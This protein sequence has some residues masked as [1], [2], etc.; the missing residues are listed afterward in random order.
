MLAGIGFLTVVT[1]VITSTF[2]ESAKRHLQGTE[3]DALSAKL[4]R[5][6]ER[7][8]VIEASLKD[9]GGHG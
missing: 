7:L 4:D 8:E 2:I 1:A 6:G 9:P 3:T 5:I